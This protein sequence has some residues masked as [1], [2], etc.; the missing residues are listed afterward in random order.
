MG[1]RGSREK[2]LDFCWL[3]YGSL[4][5]VL[6]CRRVTVAAPVGRVWGALS[7]PERMA[8]WMG[9][10]VEGSVV[11]GGSIAVGWDSMGVGIDLEVMEVEPERRLVLAGAPPGRDRQE[12]RV[13]L[14]A[15]GGGTEVVLEHD[16]LA[17][18]DEAAGTLAGWRT[19]LELLRLYVERY[20]GRRRTVAAALGTAVVSFEQLFAHYTRGEL[21]ARWLLSSPEDLGEEGQRASL[22]LRDGLELQ[23]EVVARSEP[24][25]I[26]LACD[27]IEGALALRALSL[28][29]SD[30]GAKV[31][32]AQIHSWA[33]A[34]P[35]L[36]R[37]HA[38]VASAVDR[39]VATLG[40]GAGAA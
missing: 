17:S 11:V 34:S 28:D 30:E 7:E 18:A 40:G 23:A 10:R 26:A 25:E 6:V 2:L 27:E 29:G 13:E 33:P 12:Q 15:V 5:P 38:A 16:G 32:G 35:S 14:A 22:A 3:G 1:F 39:L 36:S 31:V 37:V 8:Q 20:H 21:L 9:E 19:A 24:R 4:S